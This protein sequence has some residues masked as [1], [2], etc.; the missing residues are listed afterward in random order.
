M[1]L[2]L[3]SQQQGRTDRDQTDST[4]EQPAH[5]D[6]TDLQWIAPQQRVPTRLD[7][8]MDEVSGKVEVWVLTASVMQLGLQAERC[9]FHLQS[10]VFD[11]DEAG[12]RDQVLMWAPIARNPSKA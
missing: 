2:G 3:P 11:D 5:S 12:T 4:I 1:Q 6:W 10:R 7:G 9:G 8:I